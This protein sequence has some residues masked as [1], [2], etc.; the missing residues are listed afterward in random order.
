MEFDISSLVEVV[1]ATGVALDLFRVRRLEVRL[2]VKR[3]AIGGGEGTVRAL[4][5]KLCLVL[6]Q[7]LLV[8]GGR[9]AERADLKH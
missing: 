2:H 4:L 5:V 8:G 1:E 9:L 3:S 7:S 6:V